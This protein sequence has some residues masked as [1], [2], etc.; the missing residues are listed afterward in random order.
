MPVRDRREALLALL[1][2]AAAPGAAAAQPAADGDAAPRILE[3]RDRIKAAVAARD[4][5]TLERLFH[6]GFSHLRDSG[7]V[8]LKADRIALLLSGEVTIETAREEQVVVQAFG[9]ATA[10]ATGVSAIKDAAGKPIRFR[11]LTVYVK[12][13][14]GEWRVA[15]SQA[16]R[17]GRR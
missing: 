5:A 8:D 14:L 17:A 2:A 13:A 4:R 7:R 15:I 12:D 1:A 11:W 16:S 9:P 3:F 10:A 6:D